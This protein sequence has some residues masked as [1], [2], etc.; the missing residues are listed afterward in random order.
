MNQC[1]FSKAWIG[2]CD[3]Q[4]DDSG[5]CE[6]HKNTKCCS[7]GEQATRE[8]GHTGIQFVCGYPLCATCEHGIPPKDN[9]G[10]FGLGGGHVTAEVYAKQLEARKQ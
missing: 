1:T 3:E 6:K 9:H 5:F 4:A 8:C 7:C 2:P 10:W